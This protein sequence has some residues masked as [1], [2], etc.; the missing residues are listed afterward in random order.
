MEEKRPSR[1]KVQLLIG[2]IV[3]LLVA[4]TVATALTPRLATRNPL[5][6]ILLDARNRN[7]VLARRVDVV[8]FVVVGTLRRVLSD[9][10]FWLLGLWYG[11]KAIRWLDEKAGGGALVR[12]T[13]KVFAKAAYPM[14][15]LFPGAV[16]CALAGAT[17]M[18]FPAFIAVNLAGTVTAVVA[19][20]LAGDVLSSP[21]DSLLGFFERNMV[22]SM[23][24]TISLAVLS[25][26]LNWA[27]G[28]MEIPSVEELEAE[29]PTAEDGTATAAEEETAAPTTTATEREPE[30]GDGVP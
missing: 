22:P 15:F 5:L 25:L 21:V 13:E 12:L 8:P 26:V 3:V 6:L 2:T 16:V 1:H 4:G 9:P 27:Q 28:R 29:P 7:L 30:G 10:L 19:L 24:V 14:V 17:G 20:R 23:V 18:P 11:D